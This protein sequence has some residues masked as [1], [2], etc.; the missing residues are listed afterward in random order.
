MA[1]L[2]R[3][4]VVEDEPEVALLIHDG[5][6]EFGYAVRV[7]VD[8]HEAL[9]LV[10][11]YQPDAVLLDLWLPGLPGESVLEALRREAPEVPV[12]IVSGNSDAD[13][14]RA[15]LKRGAFDYVAK[16]FLLPVLERVVAAAIVEHERRTQRP[17]S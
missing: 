9:R 13:R 14:A 5:L 16:P 12:I 7:A 17:R 1:S 10:A 8:G 6:Q 3:V 11:D 2:G 15:L 4:L